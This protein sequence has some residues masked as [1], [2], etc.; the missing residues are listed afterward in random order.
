[1][2]QFPC[3]AAKRFFLTAASALILAG[4]AAAEENT[5]G[6]TT[7]SGIRL[8]SEPSV[9]SAVI[10]TLNNNTELNILDNSNEKWT[11]VSYNGQIGY[12]S[13]HY[14]QVNGVFENQRANDYIESETTFPGAPLAPESEI[15]A[16]DWDEPSLQAESSMFNA[17][18]EPV[19]AEDFSNQES[20]P[21][22]PLPAEN[23]ASFPGAPSENKSV[24]A[25]FSQP[26]SNAA[27][28]NA[29][30]EPAPLADAYSGQMESQSG[31]G[32]VNAFGEPVPLEDAYTGQLEAQSAA[33]AFNAFGEPVPEEDIFD[34]PEDENDYDL[35]LPD[36]AFFEEDF[37]ENNANL[38]IG[39]GMITGEQLRMHKEPYVESET[40][41]TLSKNATVALLDDTYPDW[42]KISCGGYT[43]YISSNYYM[44]LDL[45]S[46][47]TYAKVS[48]DGVAIHD[49]AF[50]ES[51]VL[52]TLNKDETVG[53]VGLEDGW[54]FAISSGGAAAGYI[55]SDLLNLGTGVSAQSGA[56]IDTAKKYLGVRYVY[57]GS[58]PRG[59]DCSGFTQYVFRQC[60]ISIPRTASTQWNSGL[61]N[62]VTNRSNL[63]P[64]DLVFFN[65]PRRNLGRACSHV[66]IYIGDGRFIHASSS[67]GVKISSLSETYYNRY[68]KG[69][70]HIAV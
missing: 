21:G 41:A 15:P 19:P 40:V 18:G 43:G 56:I 16:P 26:R 44:S 9:K 58:T 29:F 62:R 51:N 11:K 70:L 5:V 33:A 60:G 68:Y 67:S 54:Y 45:T 4:F 46:I 6:V 27:L 49:A 13:A 63:Q 42:Y 32:M 65:D 52:Q 36:E 59:F 66:G 10:T 7:G 47:E 12:V 22:A 69:G 48:G 20:F 24:T 55:R 64:G 37:Q 61:G 38:A 30:G 14:I 25:E 34:L 50:G 31:S 23:A 28:V 39:V 17:F 2:T 57:G 35:P 1:M 3:R 53:V 8:R